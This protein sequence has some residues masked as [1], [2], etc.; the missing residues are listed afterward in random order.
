[1]LDTT[2][3]HTIYMAQSLTVC[4]MSWDDVLD[5]VR[6]TIVVLYFYNLLRLLRVP[7]TNCSSLIQWQ[8]YEEGRQH[9][10][11][12]RLVR[13]G[14]VGCKVVHVS[15]IMRTT[16]I[17]ESSDLSSV[18]CYSKMMES[19]IVQCIQLIQ[20]HSFVISKNKTSFCCRVF[21]HKFIWNIWVLAHAKLISEI[22]N[23]SVRLNTRNC[24]D[25]NG[26]VYGWC[27]VRFVSAVYS[28]YICSSVLLVDQG[29]IHSLPYQ[30]GLCPI[31]KR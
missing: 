18:E 8:S 2:K 14:F 30:T 4:H 9:S 6:D 16:Q 27:P 7:W 29:R 1:M 20:R 17:A 3:P 24:H 23:L 13:I 25:A 21:W 15:M 31:H 26:T 10:S 11:L 5:T 28:I 12:N 19:E 22:S